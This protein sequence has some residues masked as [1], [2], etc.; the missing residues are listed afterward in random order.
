M[1]SKLKWP[2]LACLLA[3]AVAGCS[4]AVPPDVVDL[5]IESAVGFEIAKE[6]G[7]GDDGIYYGPDTQHS[8]EITKRQAISPNGPHAF[9]LHGTAWVRALGEAVTVTVGD[10]V[11]ELP[12]RGAA[13]IN[14]RGEVTILAA[15]PEQFHVKNCTTLRVTVAAHVSSDGCQRVVAQALSVVVAEKS[16]QVEARFNSHVT[17][18][19]CDSLLATDKSYVIAT[20]CKRVDA[21]GDTKLRI[22][23]CST[24]VAGDRAMVEPH[25][26]SE[27]V[28]TGGAKKV[29][30]LE[31]HYRPLL[32]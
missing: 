7:S 11:I 19:G 3:L 6:G 32:R 29:L 16:K 28:I 15:L 17:V 23:K 26:C 5:K 22:T 13:H 8:L 10:A 20:D 1:F 30:R 25:G 31:L 24:L 21:N 2:A 4:R 12:P 18:N 27:E 9:K 14:D